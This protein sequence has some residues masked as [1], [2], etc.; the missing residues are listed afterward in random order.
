MPTVETQLDLPAKTGR[1]NLAARDEQDNGWD[2]HHQ[3]AIHEAGHPEGEMAIHETLSCLVKTSGLFADT[4]I[5][6]ERRGKLSAALEEAGATVD[7]ASGF[8]EQI[9]E[10]QIGRASCR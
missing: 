1:D 3:N 9:R 4:E 5:L 6:L 7:L 2:N 8:Q 10:G